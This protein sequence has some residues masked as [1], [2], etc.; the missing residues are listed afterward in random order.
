LYAEDFARFDAT[1]MARPD[2][3]MVIFRVP[4]PRNADQRFD[5]TA[6]AI[7]EMMVMTIPTRCRSA[8]GGPRAMI[9]IARN[10]QAAVVGGSMGRL[11]I[12][13]SLDTF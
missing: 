10:T 12:R 2:G 4:M 8:F 9:G 6:F 11:Q 7:S 1:V 3:E 5:A 13:Y